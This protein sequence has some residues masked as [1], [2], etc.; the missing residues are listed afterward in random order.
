MKQEKDQAVFRGS[1]GRE[2]RIAVDRGAVRTPRLLPPCP[3][4][5]PDP[6]TAGRNETVVARGGDFYPGTV[7]AA[8]RRG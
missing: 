2:V 1:A 5:F 6:G 3:Y 8:Y 4:E 7:M